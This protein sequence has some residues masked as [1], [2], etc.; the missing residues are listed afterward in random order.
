MEKTDYLILPLLQAFC[1]F[2]DGL[3]AHLES[4]GW[5]H[6]TRPQSMVMINVLS[7]QNKP[8]T[9]ARNLGISRQAA[10]VTITQ[11]E[12]L[13]MVRMIED[14]ED[15]RSKIVVVSEK[16]KAMRSDADAAVQRLT[17]ELR[18][19]IG[20]GTVNNLFRAFRADW[21]PVPQP[22]GAVAIDAAPG[23]SQIDAVRDD[24]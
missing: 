10:H 14:P 23:A 19:R 22:I 20:N 7:G 8:S 21:G 17:D 16:G 3:Q 2:D 5:Q 1:W 18:S 15:G 13:D 4:R 12:K 24:V 9:I 11:L 6:I